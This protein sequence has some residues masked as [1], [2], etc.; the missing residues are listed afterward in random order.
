MGEHI[1]VDGEG[2]LSHAG[3]CDISA[4]SI[5]VLAPA[6]AGHLTQATTAAV[7]HGHALVNA[8]AAQLTERAT[9]TGTTLR[10]AAGEY[11]STDSGN[12]QTISTTI[13]V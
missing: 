4:S 12:A 10:A 5:P 11:I 13:Q 2:L 7:A 9:S 1:T 3:V 8:L 6:A